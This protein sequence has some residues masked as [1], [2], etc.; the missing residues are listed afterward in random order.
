M[1]AYHTIAKIQNI[2]P[3]ILAG[4][5][6]LERRYYQVSVFITLILYRRPY[7]SFKAISLSFERVEN[8]CMLYM[9]ILNRTEFYLSLYKSHF[10]KSEDLKLSLI[11]MINNDFLMDQSFG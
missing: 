10:P 3:S 7:I 11:D 1:L 9:T 4:I 2:K 5:Y 8:L 6:D